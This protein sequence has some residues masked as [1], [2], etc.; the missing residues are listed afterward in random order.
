[1][2]DTATTMFQR[3]L[4]NHVL[5]ETILMVVLCTFDTLYTLFCVRAGLA[6]ETN[7]VLRHTLA[8]SDFAFLLVK[9]VSFLLPLSLLELIR[10]YRPQFVERAMRIGFM[11]YA[12]FYFGGSVLIVLVKLYL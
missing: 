3:I 6:E 2:K 9:G 5:P 12:C 11:A 4:R 1:M 8:I 7:P 10:A